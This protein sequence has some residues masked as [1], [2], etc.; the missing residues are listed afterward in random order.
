MQSKDF[1][2]GEHLLSKKPVYYQ[3]REECDVWFSAEVVWEI[4]GAGI[5]NL[6]VGTVVS[7]DSHLRHTY[8]GNK[9]YHHKPLEA[10]SFC[11]SNK[12]LKQQSCLSYFLLTCATCNCKADRYQRIMHILQ[13]NTLYT[14]RFISNALIT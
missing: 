12:I 14:T 3:T 9:F 13:D 11:K 1:F 2:S 4:R 7:S 6:Q 8:F 5:L 10:K